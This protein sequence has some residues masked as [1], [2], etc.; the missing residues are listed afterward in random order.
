MEIMIGEN[1][2]ITSDA[3][4]VILN[5]RYDKKDKEG[6]VI[7]EDFKQIGFFRNLE[8]ACLFLVD[9]YL[10]Q[11]EAETVDELCEE[12]GILK[13]DIIQAVND[14]GAKQEVAR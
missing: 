14:Y 4:N 6:N 11:S 2:K 12:I 10:K 13:Q 8:K 9:R 3:Y 5:Q 7:G 1:Y